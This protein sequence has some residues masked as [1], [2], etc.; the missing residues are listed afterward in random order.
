MKFSVY[1]HYQSEERQMVD[2][3]TLLRVT[4]GDLIV[5]YSDSFHSEFSTDGADA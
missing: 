1:D 5:I 3:T 2:T 4:M